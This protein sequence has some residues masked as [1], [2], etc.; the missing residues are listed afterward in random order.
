VV[1]IAMLLHTWN[2]DLSRMRVVTTLF[3][4]SNGRW[5][6]GEINGSRHRICSFLYDNLA[7]D[8]LGGKRVS[9]NAS[10]VRA[11]PKRFVGRCFPA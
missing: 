8:W 1:G 10:I 3:Q 7:G 2:L 11:P 9:L 5:G 6:F 4:K